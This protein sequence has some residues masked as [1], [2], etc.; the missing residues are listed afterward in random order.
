MNETQAFDKL[1][2]QV[3]KYVLYK[4][5]TEA[6]IRQKFSQS[7]ESMLDDVI[8]YLQEN[9]Y[10]NDD[11]YIEKAINE[12]QKLKNM[13]IKE[14]EYKLLSKGITKDKIEN[15]I[16]KHEEK[17]IEYELN[18]AQNLYI[19]KEKTMS[20]EDIILYLRKKGYTD[21][22]IRKIEGKE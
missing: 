6:E 9:N 13:S 10:I 8:Q 7:E 18:S 19:K 16:Y 11:I 1:K 17:L 15:Y 14:I 20:K 22:T 21:E 2:T 5:R 3:L 12:F 4:K